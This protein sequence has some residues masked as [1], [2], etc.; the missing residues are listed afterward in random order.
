MADTLNSAFDRLE[1][2]KVLLDFRALLRIEPDA[3]ASLSATKAQ[4]RSLA[5]VSRYAVID[6]PDAAGTMIRL[7]DKIIPVDAEVFAAGNA[8]SAWQ[9]IEQR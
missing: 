6:P 5:N 9:F 7:A 2:V 3:M 1:E 8:R 4:F